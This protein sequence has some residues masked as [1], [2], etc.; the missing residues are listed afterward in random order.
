MDGLK[1]ADNQVNG[2]DLEIVQSIKQLE[3]ALE[4]LNTKFAEIAPASQQDI[5]NRLKQQLQLWLGSST[6]LLRELKSKGVEIKD[7]ALF[8]NSFTYLSEYL[9]YLFFCSSEVLVNEENIQE[10]ARTHYVNTLEYVDALH[11]GSKL[12]TINEALRL[13]NE[14]CAILDKIVT[15]R[16]NTDPVYV[17]PMVKVAEPTPAA[18]AKVDQPATPADKQPADPNYAEFTQLTL[19]NVFR[20]VVFLYEQDNNPASMDL[21]LKI[22]EF[23]NYGEGNYKNALLEAL[24]EDPSNNKLMKDRELAFIVSR[25]APAVVNTDVAST[26]IAQS[27]TVTE[28]NPRY[29]EFATIT[30]ENVL[31]AINFIY[32]EDNSINAMQLLVSIFKFYNEVAAGQLRLDILNALRENPEEGKRIKDGVLGFNI[33]KFILA[34]EREVTTETVEVAAVASGSANSTVTATNVNQS[35]PSSESTLTASPLPN[36]EGLDETQASKEFAIITPGNVTRAIAFLY[37]ANNNA[38]SMELMM[39]VFEF[40]RSLSYYELKAAVLGALKQDRK[41]KKEIKNGTLVSFIDRFVIV[42]EPAFLKER[43]EAVKMT[44]G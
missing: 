8:Y 18:E 4:M 5:K 41:Q 22:M 17:R 30:P 25:V 43:A 29:T 9:Q 1:I 35:A 10:R 19:H 42:E 33:R 15:E 32:T 39:R 31:E 13:I 36:I 3:T 2:V 26:T 7:T 34:K 44:E 28:L 20:A 21:L 27:T 23:Y 37:T 24:R 38:Y 16:K 11:Q 40:Y 14:V 6:Y 12:K